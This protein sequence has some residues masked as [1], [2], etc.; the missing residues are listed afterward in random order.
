MFDQDQPSDWPCL[1]D[2]AQAPR[3]LQR[4]RSVRA[5]FFSDKA[6]GFGVAWLYETLME[7]SHLEARAFRDRATAAEWL[8]VPVEILNPKDEPA[9]RSRQASQLHERSLRIMNTDQSTRLRLIA[10]ATCIVFFAGCATQPKLGG[11]AQE[12]AA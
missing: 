2:R 5:A 1:F 8:A 11:N 7:N 3:R 12:V 6:V 10:A 4:S 9:P